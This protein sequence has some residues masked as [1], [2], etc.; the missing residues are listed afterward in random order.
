MCHVTCNYNLSHNNVAFV[1]Y[2]EG[3]VP[4]NIKV[5]EGCNIAERDVGSQV[6]VFYGRINLE[7]MYTKCD[8][9]IY[10]F[11]NFS[12]GSASSYYCKIPST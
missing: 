9:I 8:K 4:H 2:T 1:L 5:F 7:S 6:G 12:N 11:L 10:Y 3:C